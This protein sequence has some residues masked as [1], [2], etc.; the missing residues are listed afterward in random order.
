MCGAV[1]GFLRDGDQRG[2][3]MDPE[4]PG[5]VCSELISVPRG[6]LSPQTGRGPPGP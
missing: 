1:R 4:Q 5:E 3:P 2:E 6:W